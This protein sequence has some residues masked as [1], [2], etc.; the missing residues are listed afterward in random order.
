[1]TGRPGCLIWGPDG[2]TLAPSRQAESFVKGAHGLM[3]RTGP[4][5]SWQASAP[6]RAPADQ[7]ASARDRRVSP[8]LRPAVQAGYVRLLAILRKADRREFLE[9][10]NGLERVDD[11]LRASPA[12]VPRL[13]DLAWE[14]RATPDFRPLFQAVGKNEPVARRDQ[15][16][17]PCNL[18]YDQIM[19]AH[20]HG[21]ARLMFEHRERRWAERR[22]RKERARRRE[23]RAEEANRKG[24]H[25]RLVG[26]VRTILD[27]AEGEPLDPEAFRASY[28][29]HG[30]YAVLKPLLRESWQ[31]GFLDLYA[32]LGTAQARALGHLIGRVQ[33]RHRIEAFIDLSLDDI[34]LLRTVCRTFGETRLGLHLEQGPRW[35]MSAQAV[36]A[37]AEAETQL[38]TVESIVFDSLLIDHM[39]AVDAI[40]ELQ[41]QAPRV[42][43]RLTPV[44]G[45]DLWSVM[46]EPDAL[47]N[48]RR[49]PAHLLP[50]LGP[51]SRHCPPDIST[52]LGQIRDRALAR[53]LMEIA[54]EALP[55]KELVRYLADPARKPI[56]NTIPAKFNNAFPYQ[57]DAMRGGTLHNVDSLR[58]VTTAI[59]HSLRLG[60]LETF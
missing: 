26:S 38:A 53:D 50:V 39:A 30:L 19:R 1:M 45:D 4:G 9:P 13:L 44:F 16:I 48:A 17:A 42:V 60:H 57:R 31:Y 6:P 3:R 23:R 20:L 49:V 51:L 43:R 15:A 22:A 35:Q 12:A 7:G 56:W 47:E 33:S 27:G 29:G 55:E 40:R 34:G 2:R 58:T 54:R 37:Q 28:P 59:L 46:D 14:L 11:V 21:S 5:S 52:I 10:I 18:T 41:D 8:E 24:L 36:E 25:G 32:R